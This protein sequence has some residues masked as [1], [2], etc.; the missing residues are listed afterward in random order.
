MNK[1]KKIFNKI[2]TYFMQIFNKKD[3]K[4]IESNSQA[5]ENFQKQNNNF[6]KDSYKENDFL[7]VYNNFKKGIIKPEEL[8]INDL[9]KVQLMMKNELNYIDDKIT[10]SEDEIR[11]I[12]NNIINFKQA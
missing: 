9:I 5:L 10:I 4:L 7:V 8:M 6:V 3:I 11:E 2:K 12:N 1:I